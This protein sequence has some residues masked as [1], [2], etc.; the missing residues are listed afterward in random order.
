MNPGTHPGMRRRWGLV[1]SSRRE[2]L[3]VHRTETE[4]VQ[5]LAEE[6]C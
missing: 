1:R 4:E 5:T 2:L 6:S 3:P